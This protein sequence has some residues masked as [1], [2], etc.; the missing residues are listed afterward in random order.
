MVMNYH[1]PPPPSSL[2]TSLIDYSAF[3]DV[4]P[5]NPVITKECHYNC[6]CIHTV[7]TNCFIVMNTDVIFFAYLPTHKQRMN[8]DFI[9]RTTT[10]C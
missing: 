3:D 10:I 9:R 6:N 2:L 7:E 8:V 5:N 4:T 1:T